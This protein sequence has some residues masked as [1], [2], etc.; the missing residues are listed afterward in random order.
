MAVEL[1]F[2]KGDCLVGD[3]VSSL[4]LLVL[5]A[6]KTSMNKFRGSFADLQIVRW[7]KSPHDHAEWSFNFIQL[8]QV[9]RGGGTE[10]KAAYDF[11]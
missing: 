1:Y 9:G 6:L 10:A 2:F 8:M 11:I 3:N 4:N 7:Q 5:R